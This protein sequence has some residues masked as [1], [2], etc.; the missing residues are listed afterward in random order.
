MFVAQAWGH[1]RALLA[2]RPCLAWPPPQFWPERWLTEPGDADPA[3][4]PA[5]GAP[6]F[7]PFRYDMQHVLQLLAAGCAQRAR[8]HAVRAA[9][10]GWSSVARL[11]MPQVCCLLPCCSSGPKNCIGG[12]LGMVSV[13][14]G[15]ALLLS[16]FRWAAQ[17]GCC[18][19]VRGAA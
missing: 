4:D 1:E 10:A 6:K 16:T 17:P 18:T 5:T 11:F 8:H 15:A 14:T 2:A 3:L 13:R 19:K 7:L 9:L 12:A